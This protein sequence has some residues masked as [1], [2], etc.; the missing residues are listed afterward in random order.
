M[1]PKSIPLHPEMHPLWIP[2]C[3][4]M[5]GATYLGIWRTNFGIWRMN[6][7]IQETHFGIQEGSI[8]V[9]KRIYIGI[10]GYAL[11]DALSH[12]VEAYFWTLWDKD[13]FMWYTTY[14]KKIIKWT[15]KHIQF[16]FLANC[17][18]PHS[19]KVRHGHIRS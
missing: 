6:Y 12:L 8:L 5:I 17:P 11:W 2:K 18:F 10:Q 7:G 1:Y 16:G 4:P 13:R 15:S 14:I 9:S 3:L 19:I